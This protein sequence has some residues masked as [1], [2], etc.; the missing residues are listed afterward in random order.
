MNDVRLPIEPSVTEVIQRLQ[1]D[2]HEAYIV[3]GAVRDLLLE[4]VPKDYDIATS[5]RPEQVKKI[6]GRRAIIIGRRFRLV[7]VFG[8]GHT[9][10][11]STFRREPTVEERSTRVTDD[12]VMIWDDNQWGTHEQDAERRDFT[13][14]AMYYDPIRSQIV[15]PVGGVGDLRAG[16]VR[17]IGDAARRLA[18]DPVRMLR[19]IKLVAQ[20]GLR[21]EESLDRA[22]H[23]GAPRITL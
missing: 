2:G 13:V 10:E 22:L 7:H 12:G 20:Y 6:F 9:F 8:G 3:G 23:E 17:A 5:A 18:E 14:N 19:A 11:V 16:T 21:P 4:I 1:Q 15:D